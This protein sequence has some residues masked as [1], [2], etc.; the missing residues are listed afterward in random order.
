MTKYRTLAIPEK[1]AKHFDK[2]AEKRDTPTKWSAVAKDALY[3]Y[4]AMHRARGA[5]E[6]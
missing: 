6:E 5:I 1:L 4:L 2:I 3:G